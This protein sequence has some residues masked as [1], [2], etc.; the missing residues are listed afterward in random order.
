MAKEKSKPKVKVTIE[1][2]EFSRENVFIRIIWEE[3]FAFKHL[4]NENT[5]HA[6]V[7]GGYFFTGDL[8]S[9]KDNPEGFEGLS[10]PSDKKVAEME[11]I[12]KYRI[13][14]PE[15]ASK[16]GKTPGTLLYKALE[17]NAMGIVNQNR[18]KKRYSKD[19]EKKLRMNYVAVNQLVFSDDFKSYKNY[20]G[21]DIG[22][23]N[24]QRWEY[25][26]FI[27]LQSYS[28]NRFAKDS[29]DEA[30]SSARQEQIGTT[31]NVFNP[32]NALDS[33]RNSE[34]IELNFDEKFYL[35]MDHYTVTSEFGDKRLKPTPHLHTGIDLWNTKGTP[36]KA[37]ADGVITFV[38][39]KSGY[40]NLIIIKHSSR[41]ETYY[42]HQ[43]K[44]APGM[45]KN[46]RV[47]KG[48]VIGYVGNTGVS[49]GP[50][51]MHLHFEIRLDGKPINPRTKISFAK[52]G[53][54]V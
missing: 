24:W 13:S 29:I 37:S 30:L 5:V 35:P 48:T 8:K 28:Y 39:Q 21:V 38:G 2:P 32:P 3:D 46:V 23:P 22:K 26:R 20:A 4:V 47:T 34:N 11:P 41:Y 18:L 54:K 27:A 45:V 52:K 40:G 10:F 53:Q 51:G 50:T 9:N 25:Y 31:E 49:M 7:V 42:A 15:Q 43:S 14:T 44:F 19:L 12:E 33:I 1:Q 17:T 6:A 36:I 16:Y